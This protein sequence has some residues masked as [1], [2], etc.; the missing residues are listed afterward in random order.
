MG[1]TMAKPRYLGRKGAQITS[2]IFAKVYIVS[3]KGFD[4]IP[5]ILNEMSRLRFRST[6]YRRRAL[7]ST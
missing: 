7:R 2:Q 1:L 4:N 6:E 3:N 5:I